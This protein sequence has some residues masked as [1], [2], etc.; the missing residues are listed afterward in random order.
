MN[1]NIAPTYI[2][3]SPRKTGLLIFG[4]TTLVV[5]LGFIVKYLVEL[6]RKEA[7]YPDVG[8]SK[9]DVISRTMFNPNSDAPKR[10]EPL[11]GQIAGLL[12][13]LTDGTIN[14]TNADAYEQAMENVGGIAVN[15]GCNK[16]FKKQQEID[17]FNPSSNL[18]KCGKAVW[19]FQEYLDMNPNGRYDTQTLIK[20]KAWLSSSNQG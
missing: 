18:D 1:P 8:E 11:K 5:G 4:V 13:G 10:T 17:E 20:H 12:A 19:E 16:K 15:V 6:D 7:G 3:K 2:A 9:M 14:A